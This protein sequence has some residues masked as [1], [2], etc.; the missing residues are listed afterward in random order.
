MTRAFHNEPVNCGPLSTI[1]EVIE[2][3]P[4]LQ[5]MLLLRPYQFRIGYNFSDGKAYQL[6]IP[7]GSRAAK[8]QRRP[9]QGF[10]N[11]LENLRSKLEAHDSSSASSASRRLIA[12]SKQPSIKLERAEFSEISVN[13]P[14]AAES[15]PF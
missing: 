12:R 7:M 2:P 6:A 4:S 8:V 11:I 13:R 9:K 14:F 3:N 10:I 5:A 1:T 15:R